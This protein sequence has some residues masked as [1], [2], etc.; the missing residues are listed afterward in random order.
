MLQDM[1][2][3]AGLTVSLRGDRRDLLDDHTTTLQVGHQ[4]VIVGSNIPLYDTSSTNESQEVMKRNAV[5][6]LRPLCLL[7]SLLNKAKFSSEHFNKL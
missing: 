3:R 4:L 2:P 5:S 6:S 7:L 1:Q